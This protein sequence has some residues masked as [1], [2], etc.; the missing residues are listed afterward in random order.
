MNLAIVM[1]LLFVHRSH[2]NRPAQSVGLA[3]NCL[4]YSTPAW[5][6]RSSA[7]I[8]VSASSKDFGSLHA[9]VDSPTPP[10][11]HSAN[12]NETGLLRYVMTSEEADEAAVP[13]GSWTETVQKLSDHQ[14]AGEFKKGDS[15][16][17]SQGLLLSTELQNTLVVKMKKAASAVPLELDLQKF[18]APREEK[19]RMNVDKVFYPISFRL[20]NEKVHK[21]DFG[22]TP[23][24]FW[25]RIGA[26][27][28]FEKV[29]HAKLKETI[30][31]R[32]KV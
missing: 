21:R 10:Q 9:L 12:D 8:A 20:R 3:T 5:H 27:Q 2:K 1:P 31:A 18:R 14:A 22:R 32:E 30:N 4:L 7:T 24:R 23:G 16:S 26:I 19:I 11:D 25:G 17:H 15:N 28:S 6:F 13:G 29:D